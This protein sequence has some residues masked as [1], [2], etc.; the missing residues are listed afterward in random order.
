MR[1]M[2]TSGRYV[3]I[4]EQFVTIQ[5]VLEDRPGTERFMQDGAQPHRTEQVFRFLD[6][7]FGN[8][9]IALDYPKFTCTGMAWPPYSPET[10]PPCW[11]IL[12]R[13]SV[14]HLNPF[15]LRH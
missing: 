2:I 7:Y 10:I 14:W 1:E 13:Q 5:L 8:R 4:L 6:E 15:L 11:T 3:A 12:N 9:V